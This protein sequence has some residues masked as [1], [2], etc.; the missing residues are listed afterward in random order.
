VPR[1]MVLSHGSGSAS[2]APR[3]AAPRTLFS[4]PCAEP[5]AAALTQPPIGARRRLGAGAQ[6]C[7]HTTACC[8]AACRCV[9]RASAE[10]GKGRARAAMHVRNRGLG[11]VPPALI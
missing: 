3:A 10:T 2:V 6:A 5:P 8:G 11:G 9:P 1:R 7:G 4:G